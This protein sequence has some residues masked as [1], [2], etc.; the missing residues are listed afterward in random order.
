MTADLSAP[1]P[2][3]GLDHVA[4]VVPDLNAAIDLFVNVL[5]GSVTFR[6]PRTDEAPP[7]AFVALGRCD[8]EIFEDPTLASAQLH[9]LG[10]ATSD[11][12]AAEVRL[13]AGGVQCCGGI[14]AGTRGPA[15]QIIPETVF[16]LSM[17]LAAQAEK[18]A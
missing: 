13:V 11:L 16:G 12:H 15:V 8:L 1:S 14:I 9:H 5:E 4:L 10:I 6:R 3:N 17:H 7:A 18:C 2:F